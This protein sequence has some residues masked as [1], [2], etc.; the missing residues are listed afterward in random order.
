MK[1]HR[2]FFS[3]NLPEEF[4]EKL[5]EVQ[6]EFR[7]LPF[8]RAE[9]SQFH[10]TAYFLGSLT[11]Q[12]MLEVLEVG[13]AVIRGKAP[14]VLRF[15]EVI[16]GPD[17]RRPR[18]IWARAKESGDFLNLQR[19]LRSAFRGLPFRVMAGRAE[20]APHITLA[21]YNAAAAEDFEVFENN[22]LPP[23]QANLDYALGVSTID[24]MESKLHRGGPEHFVL[25]SI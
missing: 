13:E 23:I 2:L 1:Q 24:L 10:V 8:K 5:T 17:V 22:A 15:D 4:K 9:P 6:G 16:Y 18:M 21:R 7:E 25:Q 19:D 14:F 11:D 20:G 12:Q 3:V